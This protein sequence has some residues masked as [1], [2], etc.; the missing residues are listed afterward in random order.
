MRRYNQAT[1]IETTA[2]AED[3]TMTTDIHLDQA[4]DSLAA[5]LQDDRLPPEARAEL[6]EDF[7]QVQSMLDKLEHGHIH[8]AVLGRVSVGKSAL[9]NALLGE[10]RGAEF[11]MDKIEDM[12]IPVRN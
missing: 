1:M 11:T 9:V 7:S 5:L 10:D 8:I 6:A 3:N 12:D 2:Y 4:R